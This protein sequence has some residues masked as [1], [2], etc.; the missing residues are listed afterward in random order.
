[1]P[2]YNPRNERIKKEYFR[3]LAGLP[4]Y[5]PHSFRDTLVQYGER[6]APTIE[7]FKAWSQNLGHDHISTTLTSYGSM[8][9]YRRSRR[10]SRSAR[11]RRR[12]SIPTP[13]SAD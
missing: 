3:F 6:H 11:H 10:G 8:S 4:Y 2:D 7:H 1:M 13:E 5:R 12:S 9:P